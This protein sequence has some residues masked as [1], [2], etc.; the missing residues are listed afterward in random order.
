MG[1]SLTTLVPN[2]KDPDK[3]SLGLG[4]ACFFFIVNHKQAISVRRQPWKSH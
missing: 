1:E 3:D 2:D 4:F